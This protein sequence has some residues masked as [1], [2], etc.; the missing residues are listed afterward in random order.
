M[1]LKRLV[2]HFTYRIEPKPEGGFIARP[3]DPSVQPLEAPTREELQKLI[4]EKIFAGLATEFPGLKIPTDG[5]QQQFAFHVERTPDGG[6]SIHSANPNDETIHA[7][8]EKD[9]E[10]RFL[11]KI[12]G[13]AGKALM[14]QLAQAIAAQAGSANIKVVVNRKTAFQVNPGSHKITLG[15]TKTLT[16]T[17]VESSAM[18]SPSNDTALATPDLKNFGT[19]DNSPITPEPS[20]FGKLLRFLPALLL[21]GALLYFLFLHYR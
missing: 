12:L 15:L 5:T 9:F 3:T 8:T 6:F 17:G 10:S 18:P 4:R 19:I 16:P 7:A 1:D 2:T 20:N 14:P 13:F 21:I 11:E